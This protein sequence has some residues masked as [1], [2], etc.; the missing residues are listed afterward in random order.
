MSLLDTHVEILCAGLVWITDSWCTPGDPKTVKETLYQ[1]VAGY[2][3]EAADDYVTVTMSLC[4]S[5]KYQLGHYGFVRIP[6][7]CIVQ[8]TAFAP[9]ILGE[10]WGHSSQTIKYETPVAPSP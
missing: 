10:D 7:K 2:I 9:T 3:V 5:T 8:M 6:K 1:R 4:E